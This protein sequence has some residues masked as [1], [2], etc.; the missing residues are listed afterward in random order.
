MADKLLSADEVIK[1]LDGRSYELAQVHH[2]YSPDHS[3]F[4]GDNYQDL[5]DGMRNYHVNDRGW[6][7]IGQHLTLYPDGA[8]MTGRDFDI[9]P[10][11]ISGHNTGA[12]M[13][14]IIGNFDKGNDK[15]EGD[16]LNAALKVYQY[17][18][19]DCGATITFHCEHAAKTCPG[20][21]L[22]KNKFVKAVKDFDG[23]TPDVSSDGKKDS[24]SGSSSTSWTKV[25]GNWTGQTLQNGQYGEPVRQLQEKLANNDPP[26]YP[27]KGADNNG[28]D[29]YY[30]DDTEDAVRRFQQIYGLGIDGMAGKEVHGKLGGGSGMS[31]DGIWGGDTTKALQEALGTTVDGI[32]SNQPDNAVTQAIIGANVGGGSSPLVVALQKKVGSGDSDGRLGPNTIKD[33]QAYLGTGVDGVISNP[34]PMVKKLQRKLNAGTF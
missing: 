2:T 15:L 6:Q 4:T 19:N 13:I 10:A 33:L 9:S 7:D 5:Q 29:S 12:F 30:G 31:V 16:Q 28:V 32:I 27:N 26:F 14:E 11:G 18:Y 24:S 3:G 1:M 23:K 20:T 25:T 8:F 34:S 21:G 17:L 22:D